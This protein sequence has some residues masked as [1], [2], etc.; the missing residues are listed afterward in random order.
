MVVRSF[1]LPRKERAMSEDSRIGIVVA[2]HAPLASA[3]VET[4]RQT[5]GEE[6]MLVG[7]VHHVDVESGADAST[8]FERISQAVREADAGS[9]VL[10]LADLFG[11]SASNVALAYLGEAQLEVVTGANLAMVLEALQRRGVA[12]GPAELAVKV[13]DAAQQSVVVA[14]TLLSAED[15]RPPSEV[16]A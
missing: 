11:G 9:G 7:P 6:L 8:S 1:G 14:S 3:L 5:V 13:A 16:T 10:L 2:A 15:R 12:S 4:A